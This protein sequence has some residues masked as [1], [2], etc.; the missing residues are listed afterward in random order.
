MSVMDN[1]QLIEKLASSTMWQS[2]SGGVVLSLKSDNHQRIPR[3]EY[4]VRDTGID[5]FGQGETNSQSVVKP[6]GPKTSAS[7]SR[8]GRTDEI[9][10]FGRNSRDG[11]GVL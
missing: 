6:S 9:Q 5:V 11:A 7:Q 2:E 4:R 8:S 3:S 1:R 10:G